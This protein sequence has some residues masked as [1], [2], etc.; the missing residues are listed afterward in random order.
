MNDKVKP[1]LIFIGY[2][3]QYEK[4][5]IEELSPNY[6]KH[7]IYINRWLLKLI[8]FFFFYSK[9]LYHEVYGAIIRQKIK[10][11]NEFD[12]IFTTDSLRDIKSISK[13]DGRKMIIFRNV[14]DGS[15]NHYL[16]DF[17]ICT[18]D[19]GDAKKY[20]FKHVYLPMPQQK[21]IDGLPKPSHY[22]VSFVG[23]DK[24]RKE[25]IEQIEGAL[26]G[27]NCNFIIFDKKSSYSYVEYL[28]KML[29]TKS[30]LEIVLD[31]QT[32]D[33]MRLKE[34]LYA[35]KKVITNNTTLYHHPLYSKENFL[36]FESLSEL[37]NNIED[38]LS[39][40]FDESALIKLKDFSVD[41]FYH[42]LLF[43]QK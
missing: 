15:L 40:D 13:V 27:V 12:I 8:A 37:T 28:T 9:T 23:V 20:G 34:A 32:S 2:K 19:I 26:K 22:D 11:L 41:S 39:G 16:D 38:F 4:L 18:F 17:E 7:H 43:N 33:T 6:E 5:E 35:R 1:K 25:A 14:T 31:G 30:V 36:I 29:N 24:G 10:K 3:Q 42:N 21:I